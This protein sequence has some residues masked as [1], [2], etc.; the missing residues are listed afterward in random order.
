MC[1]TIMAVAR[2]GDQPADRERLRAVGTDFDRNLIGRTAD[3][4][5]ADFDV[6]ADVRQRFVEHA[7]R[8]LLGAGFDRFERTVGDAFGDGLLP[9][10][11]DA[12]LEFPQHDLPATGIRS[13][14][15]AFRTTT[16]TPGY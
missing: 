5:A 3:A 11:H 2:G 7:A 14:F 8:F 4:A 10:Q 9:V 1:R 16:T 6:R 13:T 15:E 12:V